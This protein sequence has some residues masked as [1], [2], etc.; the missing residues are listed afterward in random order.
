MPLRSDQSTPVSAGAAPV[1]PRTAVTGR[2]DGERQPSRLGQLLMFGALV[3]IG[4]LTI[5][6]YLAAFP[7]L[8]TELGTTE[9]A[10]QLTLTATL[11]GLA[12]GQLLIGAVADVIG[13]RRPLLAAL[14]AYVVISMVIA[15][16]NSLEALVVLRFLQ[17]LVAAAGMVLSNAMVRDL[18]SGSQMATFISR[19]FLIVGVAPIIAPTLGA[20]FLHFGTWRTIFWALAVFGLVLVTAALFF[21]RETLPPARRRQGGIAPAL[22]SYAVLLGD[23]RFVGL[24]LTACTAMGALFAYISSATFIFQDLY[25]M[26]TQEYALVFAGGAGALTVASQVNGFLVKKIHPVRILMVALPSGL[27]ISTLLLAAA[28]LD[29]GVVAVVA[30]V[31]LVLGATGFVMP[32]APVIAL[33]DHGERAGSAAAL[34]G[35]GNFV[36]GALIAPVTGAFDAASAVPMAA[37]MV[38][39]G[40]VSLL[41]YWTLARPRDILATMPWNEDEADVEAAPA[42][43]AASQPVP[44]PAAG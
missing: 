11:V 3:A 2:T 38:G 25:G 29:L 37:V 42:E 41:V 31:V 40:A 44:G 14:T 7:T 16:S 28:L 27:V 8:V 17:G 4:P 12:I 5:D 24:V 19:L 18:Y 20:Q 30:G 9:A 35:A 43:V 33:N 34:L 26:S 21:T 32:N 22:R 15:L 13:R 39:C 1:P 23:R 36:F 10:V 6:I